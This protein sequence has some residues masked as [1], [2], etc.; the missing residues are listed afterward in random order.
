MIAALADAGKILEEPRYL[1][2]GRRAADFVLATMRRDGLLLVTYRNGAAKLNAY[3]D[4]YAFVTHHP[5]TGEEYWSSRGPRLAVPTVGDGRGD[6]GGLK[7]HG[8][9]SREF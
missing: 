8:R 3:I 7:G 2:A 4:D 9:H 6:S 1:E 5:Q